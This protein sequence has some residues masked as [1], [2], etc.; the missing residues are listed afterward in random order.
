MVQTT[1]LLMTRDNTGAV[2]FGRVPT[3]AA[4]STELAD[5]VAQEFTAPT[6]FPKYLAIF[7][8]Q[9]GKSVWCSIDGTAEVPGASVAATNSEGNPTSWQVPAG[10]T[11]SVI[12]N[13]TTAE[14]GVSFYAVS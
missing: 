9:P 1:Q 11:I 4:F 3:T 5:G 2:T 13:D 14:V 10:S 7:Y 6:D 8:F 12:T